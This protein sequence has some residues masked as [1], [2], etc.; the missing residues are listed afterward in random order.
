MHTF[1]RRLVRSN[2]YRQQSSDSI[3]SDPFAGFD[4]QRTEWDAGQETR[5]DGRGGHGMGGAYP[6]SITNGHTFN[7]VKYE[8]T[9]TSTQYS[10]GRSQSITINL[11]GKQS[12]RRQQLPIHKASSFESGLEAEDYVPKPFLPVGITVE[13][14]DGASAHPRSSGRGSL[15]V[16]DSSARFSP[17]FA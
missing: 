3:A 13:D 6:P 16:S 15:S 17:R 2:Q 12:P 8:P 5:G 10:H 11:P 4:W 7:R 9:S 1:F 14:L